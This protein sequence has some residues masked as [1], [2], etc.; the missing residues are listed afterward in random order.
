MLKITSEK[1]PD[2]ARLILEGQLTGLWVSE[3]EGVW[4]KI[5]QSGTDLLLVDLTG[6][7]FIGEDG[8]S[9]LSRMWREGAALIAS[10]CST[11]HMVEE[12]TGV[13]PDV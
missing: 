11:G 12:I 2:S 9:L 7:T 3:L 5:R 8:R 1:I 13:R 6:V 4:N 10:G